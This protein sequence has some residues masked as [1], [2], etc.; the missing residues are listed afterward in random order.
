MVLLEVGG[1]AEAAAGAG[2][3]IFVGVDALSRP[4]FEGLVAGKHCTNHPTD[5]D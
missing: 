1:R 2:K 3:L 5:L 4:V